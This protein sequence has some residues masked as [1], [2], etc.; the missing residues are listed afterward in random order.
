[1]NDKKVPIPETGLDIGPEASVSLEELKKKIKDAQDLMHL[2]VIVLLVMVGAM[3][4]SYI[5][6]VYSGSRNDDYKYSLLEKVNN[7]ENSLKMLKICLASSKWLN[8]KCF[9]N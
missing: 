7:N 2:V 4:F 9:E 5:E 3:V 8:P 1:M 6:F